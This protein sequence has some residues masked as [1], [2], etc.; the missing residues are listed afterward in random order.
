MYAVNSG[1]GLY[2]FSPSTTLTPQLIT[3]PNSSNFGPLAMYSNGAN[4]VN[5][6]NTSVYNY[7]LQYPSALCFHENSKILCL[8]ENKETYVP[9]QNISKGTLVKTYQSGYIPVHIIGSSKIYNESNS[10]RGKNRLFKCTKD[11]YHELTE[12]LIIT[13]CHSILVDYLTDEQKELS[14][15]ITGNIYVTENKYRLI[16]MLDERTELLE[17]EGIFQIWHF[18]LDSDN[19][20]INYGVYANGGLLVESTSKRMMR[21]YSGMK[22]L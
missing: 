4:L 18:A 10:I 3:S 9:I 20:Y 17:E 21:D 2:I 12:D 8:I 1:V 13:G 7:S 6:L 5:G 15:E 19:D 16:A 22:F 14:K 11:K